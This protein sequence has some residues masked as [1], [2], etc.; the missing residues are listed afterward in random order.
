MDDNENNQSVESAASGD[1]G[2][3]SGRTSVVYPMRGGQR[4]RSVS[5]R[6]SLVASPVSRRP[7][8]DRTVR[9]DVPIGPPLPRLARGSEAEQVRRISEIRQE[10]LSLALQ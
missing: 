9:G 6:P 10:L 2:M 7:M 3:T 5:R 1:A 4:S 8:T